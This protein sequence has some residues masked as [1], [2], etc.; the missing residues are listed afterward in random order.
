MKRYKAVPQWWY[1]V[2]FLIMFGISIAFMYVYDTGLPWYGLILAIAINL[3]VLVPIG[4]MQAVCN[5]SASTAVLSAF[6]AGFIWPGNMMNNVIFK[7]FT[8]TSTNQGLGYVKDMK[9]GHYMVR[10]V[11]ANLRVVLKIRRKSLHGQHLPLSAL[12]S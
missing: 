4:I 10:L 5:I 7:I 11:D 6:I 3:V 12:G 2:V 9:I 1:A 8:L